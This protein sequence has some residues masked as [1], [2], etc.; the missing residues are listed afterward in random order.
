MQKVGLIGNPIRHSLSPIF[1][2]AAIRHFGLRAEYQL[3]EI[4]PDQLVPTVQ[5]LR[6]EPTY[7]G[8]NVTTPY[9]EACLG[10]VDRLTPDAQRVGALNTLYKDAELLIGDN[11]DIYGAHVA[12]TNHLG[13]EKVTVAL[14]L[15][16]G[17]A[18]RAVIDVLI[19]MGCQR[20]HLVNRNLERAKAIA[21][22]VR[23]RTDVVLH[24]WDQLQDLLKQN[25]LDLLVNATPL[26]RLGE[27]LID[28]DLLRNTGAVFD[29]VYCDTPL[30]ISARVSGVA[31]IN[32]LP[33]LVHQ[34]AK[35]FELWFGRPAPVDVMMDA[36]SKAI[37]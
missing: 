26:G 24:T 35:S 2:N 34:G 15:G 1:Q 14:I 37:R 29:L 17:G 25:R 33:M 10:L 36:A 19:G 9:K 8:A 32:G 13:L 30:V 20:L 12:L 16:A 27:N 7:L 28:S 21:E 22:W 31:A 11:T 18:A 4:S 23:R 6:A 3:W 5:R